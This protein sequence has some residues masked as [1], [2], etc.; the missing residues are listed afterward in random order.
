MAI[1]QEQKPASNAR[2][3]FYHRI[4]KHDLAPLWEVLGALVVPTPRTP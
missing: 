1:E 4:D 2:A 3:D